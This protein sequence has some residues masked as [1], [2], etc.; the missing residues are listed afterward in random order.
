MMSSVQDRD[1][2]DRAS[3][4][5]TL[6]HCFRHNG[7]LDQEGIPY[8]L[9]L[10]QDLYRLVASEWVAMHTYME[11]DLSTIEWRLEN[12]KNIKLEVLESFLGHLFTFRRRTFKYGRLLDEQLQ[13]I[14]TDHPVTWDGG[15]SSIEHAKQMLAADFVHV[16]RLFNA[17][18]T[19]I[20]QIFSIIMPLISIRDSRASIAQ[21]RNLGFL[22]ALATVLLPF[23]AVAATLAIPS[24]YGPGGE[25]FWV[26]WAASSV[27]CIVV[28]V[29][30]LVYGV[31]FNSRAKN[32]TTKATRR[33]SVW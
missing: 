16:Q 30:F 9:L 24:P 29:S 12:E 19:R 13:S 28:L 4:R 18:T 20:N 2:D 10:L 7:L 5:T 22:T 33:Q 26:F 31:V 8:P 21:N 25:G 6:L 23:N 14:L 32:E 3:Y 17:N 1:L 15:Q 11:R 27:V